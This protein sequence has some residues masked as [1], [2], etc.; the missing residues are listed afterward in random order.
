MESALIGRSVHSAA[1]V[2]RSSGADYLIFGTVFPSRSKGESVRGTGPGPLAEIVEAAGVPVL[3]IGGI[4][5]ERAAA[6]RDAGAWGLAAIGV[7]LP[8]GRAPGAL[9]PR[10]ATSALR[11]A[12]NTRP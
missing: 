9:G 11:A 12:W 10:A 8:P 3:A 2:D 7:F 6:C 5:P 4:T 1:D